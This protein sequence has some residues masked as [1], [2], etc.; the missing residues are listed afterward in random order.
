VRHRAPAA[1]ALLAL[2]AG[3]PAL[4][5]PRV[6]AVV[7]R[8]LAPY[9]AALEGFRGAFPGEVEAVEPDDLADVGAVDLLLAVGPEAARACRGTTRGPVLFVMV[10]SPDKLEL[11]GMAGVT[12]SVPPAERLARVAAT[13]PAVRRLGVP[14]DPARNADLVARAQA[15]AAGMGLQVV[16]LPARSPGDLPAHFREPAFDALWLV[17]DRTV[18]TRSTLDYLLRQ[19]ALARIPVVGFN[20]WFARNGAVM[21]VVV[22]YADVGRQAAARASDLLAGRWSG[23]EGPRTVRTLV[24]LETARRIG[25]RVS[26]GGAQVVGGRR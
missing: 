7:S 6:V 9:Q 1:T 18:I 21:S 25:V 19:A 15:A 3:A 13:L 17:P 16:P 20:R 24:N 11:A 4:A 8:D 26:A 10:L 22:D 5:A 14:Y 2:L 12:L 23:V